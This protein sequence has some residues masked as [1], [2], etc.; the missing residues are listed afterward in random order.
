MAGT[1]TMPEVTAR[2]IDDDL[3]VARAPARP[4]TIAR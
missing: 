3:P 4:L 2:I 1:V